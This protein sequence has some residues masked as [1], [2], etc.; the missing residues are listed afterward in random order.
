[1]R[2]VNF[3]LI[4]FLLCCSSTLYARKFIINCSY[5]SMC[6]ITIYALGQTWILTESGRS[7]VEGPSAVIIYTNDNK[8]LSFYAYDKDGNQIT[9]ITKN[10]KTDSQGNIIYTRIELGGVTTYQKSES[11]NYN[12]DVPQDFGNN[13]NYGSYDS[14]DSYNDYSG[15]LGAQ[16][17]SKGFETLQGVAS[18]FGSIV[19]SAWGDSSYGYPYLSLNLGASRMYGE[20]ARLK[21]CF[22]SYAGYTLFGGIGKEMI[23]H[24]EN[25]DKLS[26]HAGVG[27]YINP[28]CES[29]HEITLSVVYSESP[30]VIG[31]AL[32]CDI[33]Y[34]YS[35]PATNYRLGFFIGAAGGI[36]NLK[37]EE[38]NWKD[39]DKSTFVW[40]VSLGVN[41]KIFASHSD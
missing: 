31:Q 36:G 7:D 30:A 18:H 3:F 27:Y 35:L 4:I 38:R 29:E 37:G 41:F 8:D 11:S 26:W 5:R 16:A 13:S 32:S 23:F 20:Y 39:G 14:A 1:M 40:D 25:K 22:G 6:P 17:A 10:S 24:G 12:Y 34:T 28:D 19:S 33:G 15:S 21:C 2:K 9:Q